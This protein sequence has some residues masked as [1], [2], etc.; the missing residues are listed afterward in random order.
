[1]TTTPTTPFL[2]LPDASGLYDPV[3][4]RDSCGLAMVATLRGTPGH[5]IIDH[6][7]DALRNMEH[8]GAVG[9]DAGT[10]DGAGILTQIPDEFFR[11]VVG[12]ELPPAGR[13]A[14]GNAL[15]PTDPAERARVKEG[16]A[17]LAASEE[18]RILEWRAVP[19]RPDV[20]GKLA[21]EAMP[22]IEQLFIRS[23]R[24]NYR[25]NPRKG[26]ALDRQCYRLRKRAEHEFGVYF[27]SLSCRTITYKGMV[28]TLQ[29]EPFYPDLHDERFASRLAVVHSRY[30]TNT[31]P[32]WPLAQPLRMTAHNGE[33]NTVRGN[34]NWM[35]ARQSQLHSDL[36]GDV[37]DL[38]PIVTEGGSDSASFD[39]VLELLTLSGRSLAH[40]V[41][42]LVPAAWENAEDLPAEVRDFYEYHS[43]LMEPWDGPASMSFTDGRFVC[44][45]LDRNGLRPGRFVVT[46]D[47]LVVLGSEVG[48]LDLDPASIERKGRL[49]PG[50]VLLVDTEVGRIIEDAEVKHDLAELRP[51]G[52]WLDE[53]R[54]N[55]AELP[56]RE[57]VTHTPASV[58]RRQ[59]A[60]GYTEE[61]L[62]VLLAPMARTGTE[63]I[64]AMGTD[65]PIAVLSER[66]RLLFDYFTQNFAQVTNPPLDAIR[67][68]VVTSLS[69]SIG[70]SENLLSQGPE[71]VRQVVVDFPVIDND[72]LAKIQH[73][74]VRPG[75]DAARTLRGLYRVEGGVESL[76]ARLVE[77]FDEADA[78]IDDG[79]GFLI[80]SD[81]DSNRDYAPIPSLLMIAAVHHHLIATQRRMRVGLVVEAGDVR[82]VHHVAT[83]LGY[84]ASAVNPYLAM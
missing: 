57:H 72:Q 30:S 25:G 60:F 15:L 44:S 29:L 23:E 67:E 39:E 52:D 58:E 83:L 38:F 20:L 36:L 73:L 22:T 71:H 77:L 12:M 48:V 10:G 42:M 59:R 49:R 2:G 54:I 13:Y 56:D 50:Q 6:A 8:R 32:S 3:H 19:T 78:A 64:G 68:A 82:E 75:V 16:I 51:W 62:R 76:R 74:E 47:G 18:L 41:H 37:R 55:L 80:L 70:P 17:R 61:E 31:F 35:R 1:M 66:P 7:L 21:R 34:R 33:I 5:D 27:M 65:T 53:G 45:T 40:A 43:M 46:K 14:V 11:A 63:P 9:S 81:R 84:G 26:L 24:Q 79:V 69:T 4:E 28:T